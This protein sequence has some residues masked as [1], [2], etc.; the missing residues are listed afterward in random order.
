MAAL[1]WERRETFAYVNAYIRPAMRGLG[2]PFTYVS[3]KK[4]SRPGVFWESEEGNLSLLLPAHTDQSGEYS[5]LPELCSGKWKQ[6]VV[7]RWMDE[8]TGWKDRGVDV[9]FGISWEEKRRRRAQTKQWIRPVYPLLDMLPKC[10]S[11]NACLDAVKTVGWPPPLR[12]RCE[13]CPNQLDAEWAEL[14]PDEW[15]RACRLDET[16]RETDPHAYLHRSLIPLRQVTL[17]PDDGSPGLF[18]GGC[19]AGMCS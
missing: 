13:H 5:K 11:V 7:R 2:I 4:Y 19:S 3:R 14:T 9:W 10:F 6:D 12:S 18:S 1:E 16:I 8:Q 15:E 17:K